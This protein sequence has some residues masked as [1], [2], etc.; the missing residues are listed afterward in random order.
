MLLDKKWVS[1]KGAKASLD[2]NPRRER[3]SPKSAKWTPKTRRK[4][5]AW[6]L[7]E[8]KDKIIIEKTKANIRHF[9]K[10]RSRPSKSIKI[11]LIITWMTKTSMIFQQR[12]LKLGSKIKDLTISSRVSFSRRR[13]CQKSTSANNWCGS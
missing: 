4:L 3:K 6:W 5:T 8:G 12:R 2:N 11:N 1:Q 9:P 13:L 10:N 7:G